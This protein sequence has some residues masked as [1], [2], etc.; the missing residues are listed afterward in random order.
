MKNKLISIRMNETLLK[1]AETIA[2]N[3]G[4]SN[5]QEF[6]RYSVRESIANRKQIKQALIE[7][8]K[9]RGSAK[10]KAKL[11]SKEEL[12]NLIKKEYNI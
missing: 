8:E 4:F 1:D 5:I 7:L 2:D 12:S 6:I 9:L 10:G 11:L 3:E